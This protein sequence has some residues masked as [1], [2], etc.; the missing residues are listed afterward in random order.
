MT[1]MA[2]WD[3]VSQVMIIGGKAGMWGLRN[4]ELTPF[5]SLITLRNATLEDVTWRTGAGATPIGSAIAGTPV[6]QAALDY[7]TDPDTQRTLVSCG[8]GTLRK[9]DQNADNWVTL[10]SGLTVSGW[11]PL[12]VAGGGER[13]GR[14]QKAFHADRVNAVRVLAAN[15]ATMAAIA[16]PANEW[17]AGNQP[18]WLA[19]D[20]WGHLWAGGTPTFQGAWRSLPEDQEDFLTRPY[21]LPVGSGIRRTTAALPYKGGLLVWGDP[22][23]AW[24]FDLREPNDQLWR[25]HRVGNW[26]VPGPGCVVAAEDDVVG[27]DAQGGIHLVSMTDPQ[28]TPRS[29]DISARQLGSWIREN[30]NRSQLT[31]AQLIWDGGRQK[32]SIGCAAIGQTQKNQ[33]IDLDLSQRSTLGERWLYWDADRNEALFMRLVSGVLQPAF[34]D[35]VGRVWN[36]EQAARNRNGSGYTFEWFMR[37][38]DLSEVNPRW[39]G[40]DKNLRFLKLLYDARVQGTHSVDIWRD[41]EKKQTVDFNLVAGAPTL[42]VTLPFT[43]GGETLQSSP[44]HRLYGQAERIALR[45]ISTVT[46]FD[47]SIAGVILGVELAA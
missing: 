32:L 10:A 16:R 2:E 45:G 47:I 37:D 30:I 44:A 9:G 34:G 3:G 40:R 33:R 36:L 41:G 26:G 17:V 11:V 7:W 35:G 29:S 13:P 24:W 6:I 8:D 18:G 1:L 27:I 25:V 15:G 46:D 19:V 21:T 42:P 14:A 43:L 23:G 4:R 20:E 22:A 5:A 28:G 38:T 12:W 31:S 39:R